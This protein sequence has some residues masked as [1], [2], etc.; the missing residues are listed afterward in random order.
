MFKV[1]RA[2]HLI[3]TAIVC[4][5]VLVAVAVGWFAAVDFALRD[6]RFSLTSRPAS[7]DIV[8]VETDAA[9]LVQ[10][11]S[12]SRARSSYAVA[13]DYLIDAGASTVVLDV[14]LQ[15]SLGYFDDN[16]LAD[17]ITRA[18][19][20]VHT[21]A[22]E[23]RLSDGSR[24]LSMPSDRFA[25]IAPP[26]YVDAVGYSRFSA[27]YR[28]RIVNDGWVMESLA[29]TLAHTRS[30]NGPGFLIDFSID[31]TTVP[32]VTLSDVIGGNV[33]P[34]L[35]QGRQVVMGQAGYS[36]QSSHAVPRYEMLSTPS[37][38]ILAAETLQ[39]DRALV[40][41]GRLPAIVIILCMG[42][43]FAC[44]RPRMT[45]GSAIAG[46]LA[47]AGILEFMALALQV[48]SGLLLDTAGIHFAQIGF[49]ATAFWHEL[50]ARGRS[51]SNTAHERDS[52]RGILARVVADNFDGVVVV[53]H[54]KSIRAASRLAEELIAPG[55][56]GAKITDV[57]PAP[58]RAALDAALDDGQ[59]LETVSE[60]EISCEGRSRT[61]EFVVT[62]SDVDAGEVS[63]E[64]AGRVACLTFRD[65]TDRRE[66]EHRLTYLAQHDPLTGAASRV[67]FVETIGELLATPSGRFRGASV[68]LVGL[69]RLKKVND[70]L[71]HVY[72]DILL[73][74]VVA[75]LQLL[76]PVSVARL[77]GNG[78]AVLR[79]G[80]LGDDQGRAFAEKLIAEVVR[81]YTLDGHRALVGA[82][83]G[84]TD[85]DLSGSA[86]DALVSH[87]GVAL[88]IASDEAGNRALAF[89]KEMDTRIRSKQDME[90]ALRAALARDEF[91]VHYQT[92]VD[93]ETGEII[94]VEALA[95]WTHPE[96]GSVSPAKFIPA[97]EETG[98]IIELG[99][100]ILHAATK[101]VASW[102]RPLSLS[103]NVSPLQFEHGDIVADVRSA[104]AQSGLPA[105]RLNIEITESLMVTE[106]SPV[107]EKLEVLRAYGVGIAL[108]DFGTGY[109]SLGYLGRLPVDTIKID[110]C[111][112][113][114]LPGDAEAS[115]IIRAVLMISESLG[116]R[117]VAEGIENQ[118][119]AWLLRLAGC[120]TGQGYFFSRPGPAEDVLA[121]L[122]SNE[123]DKLAKVMRSG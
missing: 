67:K 114:G 98:L 10:A 76:G 51:L 37:L 117:V 40:D 75:R 120:E 48:H 116:K 101:E 42:V 86:P 50:E 49:L 79:E 35:F 59:V 106:T 70:T 15:K 57:L 92:Q 14:G 96:L 9:A 53:D 52:M 28:S 19:G 60:V 83:V 11:G 109:S 99:R 122:L 105:D 30:F 65:V 36:Q 20:K 61:V 45:L 110:Q 62:L 43:L 17:A 84:M 63:L 3:V 32:R 21:V 25:A 103:V 4:V 46:S 29:T 80:L 112:V 95:R 58:F 13:L 8:F 104:L 26:V 82:R 102:P 77:E 100:W 23:T 24:A 31:L 97:A 68:F 34:G 12:Q 91:S 107:T 56:R 33:Q 27:F 111:F 73:K 93:L 54:N 78:F 74:Q 22:V 1:A 64:A 90:I 85:S 88:S 16:A 71:G 69:S 47:Y 81:P 55:L 66:V 123:H 113:R 6:L 44:L 41:M 87:A 2:R 115:A 72:G 118:D 94:G 89:S 5:V 38:Q 7:G 39:L 18:A 121:K 108:D 119:Q